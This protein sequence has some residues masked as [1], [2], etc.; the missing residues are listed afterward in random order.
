[1]LLQTKAFTTDET[2]MWFISSFVGI[3]PQEVHAKLSGSVLLKRCYI[4]SQFH[5]DSSYVT[6]SGAF[7]VIHGSPYG[8]PLNHMIFLL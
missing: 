7:H 4:K 1:M 6:Y 8:I 3:L 2:H 5:L